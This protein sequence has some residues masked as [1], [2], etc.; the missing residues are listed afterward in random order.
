[1]RV[2]GFCK[3][4][5]ASARSQHQHLPRALAMDVSSGMVVSLLPGLD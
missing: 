2:S 4:F 5:L 3:P 1:M